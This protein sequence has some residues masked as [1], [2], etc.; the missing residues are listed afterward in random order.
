[1]ISK[2][3]EAFIIYYETQDEEAVQDIADILEKTYKKLTP[4]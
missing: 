1:M 4:R 3:T 2:E